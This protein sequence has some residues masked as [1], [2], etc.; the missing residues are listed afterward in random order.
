VERAVSHSRRCAAALRRD[1]P[2]V[3]TEVRSLAQR[4]AAP[5]KEIESVV[6]TSVA[7]DEPDARRR[8]SGERRFDHHHGSTDGERRAGRGHRP[9]NRAVAPLNDS[10]QQDAAL[11]EQA[12]ARA[13]RLAERAVVLGQ[14][15]RPFTVAPPSDRA[16][17]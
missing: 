10:T 8:R 6:A 14:A 12:A 1:H 15:V 3:A 5:A 7:H 16:T 4:C 2:C 17:A 13:K 11:V 9:V